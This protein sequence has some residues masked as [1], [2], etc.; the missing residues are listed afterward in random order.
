MNSNKNLEQHSQ[1]II[2]TEYQ[3]AVPPPG[4]LEQFNKVNPTYADKIMQMAIDASQ[5]QND[6]VLNQRLQIEGDQRLREKEIEASKE[7]KDKQIS[8]MNSDRMFQ[9]VIS[10]L[11]LLF[12]AAMCFF[13]LYVAKQRLDAGETFTA[14]IIALVPLLVVVVGVFKFGRK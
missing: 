2:A 7:L 9:N 14:T 10:L 13:L 8:G 6:M 12:T 5:R 1:N 3:G 4:M 11:G